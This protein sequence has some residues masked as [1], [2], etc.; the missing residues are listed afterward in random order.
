MVSSFYFFLAKIVHVAVVHA[1]Y[2]YHRYAVF[3]QVVFYCHKWKR[4]EEVN[5]ISN[6]AYGADY[7]RAGVFVL[8]LFFSVTLALN[9]WSIPRASIKKLTSIICKQSSI[10]FANSSLFAFH[11]IVSYVFLNSLL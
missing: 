4:F 9:I 3:P 2:L 11:S 8:V 1:H 5:H 10:I 6:F 7:F